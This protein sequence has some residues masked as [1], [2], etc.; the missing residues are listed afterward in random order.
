LAGAREVAHLPRIGHDQ[1]Q[2]GRG[3]RRHDATLVPPGSFQDDERGR[4]L[5]QR[6]RP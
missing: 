1:R 6:R 4:G 5:A 2:Q 3:K